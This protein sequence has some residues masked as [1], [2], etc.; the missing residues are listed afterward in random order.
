MPQHT[1]KGYK[2]YVSAPTEN[3]TS[4]KA[5]ALPDIIPGERINFEVDDL[6]N[7]VGIVTIVRPNGYIVTQKDFSWEEKDQ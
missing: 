2:L 6:Y 4:T 7:G 5:Y 1:V 3:Y